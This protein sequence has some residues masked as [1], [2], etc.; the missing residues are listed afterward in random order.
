MRMLTFND[1]WDTRKAI[2]AIFWKSGLTGIWKIL[3]NS[4]WKLEF[5]CY[6]W[7]LKWNFQHHVKFTRA[8]LLYFSCKAVNISIQNVSCERSILGVHHTELHAD[9]DHQAYS[10]KN[11][12][13][14]MYLGSLRLLWRPGLKPSRDM[15]VTI[16][17]HCS[18]ACFQTYLPRMA[19]P[20]CSCNDCKQ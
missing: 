12:I 9:H 7:S 5:R 19:W 15:V 2:G 10:L 8:R 20:L 3:L 11:I 1:E 14:N 17:T 16:A 6:K 13:A 18:R 4:L